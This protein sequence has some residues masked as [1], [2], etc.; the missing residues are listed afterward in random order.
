MGLGKA[1]SSCTNSTRSSCGKSGKNTSPEEKN[2][3]PSAAPLPRDSLWEPLGGLSIET[4]TLA[5]S[6][7]KQDQVLYIFVVAYFSKLGDNSINSQRL[8]CSSSTCGLL[9]SFALNP[10][11]WWLLPLFTG[12]TRLR[13]YGPAPGHQVWGDTTSARHSDSPAGLPPD[14]PGMCPSLSFEMSKK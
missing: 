2:E 6:S 14:S 7:V 11:R 5:V 1:V 12:Q 8:L 4:C 3:K 13:R 9:G 10:T